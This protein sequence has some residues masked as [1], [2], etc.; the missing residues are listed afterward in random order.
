MY[1]NILHNELYYWLFEN[2]LLQHVRANSAPAVVLD[3][4]TSNYYHLEERM[5]CEV[6]ANM[7]NSLTRICA[8]IMRAGRTSMYTLSP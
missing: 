4:C 2:G 6:K 1:N 5:A 7:S 3:V 8:V